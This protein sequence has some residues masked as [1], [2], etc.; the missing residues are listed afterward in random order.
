[1]RA[2]AVSALQVAFESAIAAERPVRDLADLAWRL[3]AAYQAAGNRDAAVALRWRIVN[4]WPT[5]LQALQAMNDLGAINVPAWTRGHIYYSNRRWQPA[6]DALT[7]YINAGAPNGNLAQA[8]YERAVALTRLGDDDALAAL[9]RVADLHGD[10][11]WA[12]EALWDAGS[13]LLRKGD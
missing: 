6:A 5:T 4:N 13:L 11:E 12:P 10:S 1:N 8:R 2:Q 3:V 7:G 9:D